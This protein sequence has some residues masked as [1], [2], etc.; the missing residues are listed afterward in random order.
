MDGVIAAA[1]EFLGDEDAVE[2][3]LVLDRRREASLPELRDAFVGFRDADESLHRLVKRITP[4]LW[5]VAGAAD[6]PKNLWGFANEDERLFAERFAAAAPRVPEV[7]LASVFRSY[8]TEEK[9]TDEQRI[10]LLLAF[11]EFVAGLDAMGKEGDPRLGVGPAA[12][13][14]TFAWH[15]LSGGREPVFL[16]ATNKAIKALAEAGLLDARTADLIKGRELEH[17]FQAF[18]EV[19]RRLSEVVGDAPP[20]MRTGWAIEH[21]LAWTLDRVEGIP[22][23]GGEP[24]GSGVWRPRPRGE[25]PAAGVRPMII[26]PGRGEAPRTGDTLGGPPSDPDGPRR[27][28]TERLTEETR[29]RQR[30]RLGQLSSKKTVV[31]GDTQ[32]IDRSGVDLSDALPPD[33]TPP[34]GIPR[35][36][37]PPKA[38]AP[39][40]EPAK[41]EPA[42]PEPPRIEPATSSKPVVRVDRTLGGP[43]VEPAAPVAPSPPT[44][45]KPVVRVERP[46]VI[47]APR[48]EPP[49]AEPPRPEPPKAEPARPEPKEPWP[50]A[51]SP[52]AAPAPTSSPKPIPRLRPDKSERQP[53]SD[54]ESIDLEGS[55]DLAIDA[56]VA[57]MRGEVVEAS[58]GEPRPAAAAAAPQQ[59]DRLARD[60]YL[61]PALVDEL[62]AALEQRGRLLLTGPPFAG[63]TYVARRLAIH[64]AGH[65]D[66]VM[67]LRLHPELAYSDLMGRQGDPGIVRALCARA[68][69][70][71]EHRHVLVLDELDRGDAAR[72]LGELLGALSERGQDVHLGGSG[73]PF[74][75]PRN[76][77]VVATARELPRDP[78]LVGRFPT[79][80]LPADADV[81]R[82]WL[83]ERRPGL[84]WV[85]DVLRSL[86]ARLRADGCAAEVGHGV[87]MDPELDATRVRQVW[88]REVLPLL[89]AQGVDKADLDFEALR[90]R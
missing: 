4:L 6:V 1:R 12:N 49:K 14:L 58:R 19:S 25:E 29:A 42:K 89:Q 84:E 26:G 75:A 71:K 28:K 83:A 33:R 46:A 65:V 68:A 81:L 7:D 34:A 55:G 37:E 63:K 36:D 5:E 64:L 57:E 50:L 31:Y 54:E 9:K 27:H 16:Y 20:A 38:E 82:R 40:P 22:Q 59:Q 90:G 66:R 60:L 48:A 35:P 17:R 86:N 13:F 77:F 41:P 47:E 11:G 67:I 10:Q 8:L 74:H 21:A 73:A 15:C 23:G 53:A 85:A 2:A 18:F 44:S 24:G 61:A 56:L 39:T 72:A 79:A 70:E 3:V 87:F 62:L 52:A 32:V 78:A 69:A 88:K 80:T 45:G 43:T 76:L 30:D 51:P